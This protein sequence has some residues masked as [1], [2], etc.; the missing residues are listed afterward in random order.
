MEKK[1]LH[2]YFIQKTKSVWKEVLKFLFCMSP[3]SFPALMYGITQK[4]FS[5]T[6]QSFYNKMVEI[7]MQLKQEFEVKFY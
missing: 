1:N 5:L 2:I 3:H 4:L 7:K 6:P